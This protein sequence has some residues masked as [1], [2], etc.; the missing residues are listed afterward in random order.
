[1]RK[2]KEDFTLI[3]LLVVIAIIAILAA[4]LLPA[5]SNAREKGRQVSCTNKLKQLGAGTAFYQQ[6]YGDYFPRAYPFSGGWG[7]LFYNNKYITSFEDVTCPSHQG[8]KPSDLTGG[9]AP[10]G[11]IDSHYGINY[12]HVGGSYRYITTTPQRDFP[13]K[14]SLLK[15]PSEVILMIETIR[16]GT[17]RGCYLAY[18]TDL[19]T[20][21]SGK[22]WP[23]HKNS[24]NVL[25]C[26]AHVSNVSART[27]AEIYSSSVLGNQKYETSKWR[28]R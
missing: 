17:D 20:S 11:F 18:D 28:R 24:L 2:S 8:L 23:K 7:Q 9:G 27:S 14:A 6:D 1:M 10:Y 4:M 12:Y 19:S 21:G 15:S 13:L 26:D 3:E 5:L 25:W 16:I 22:A